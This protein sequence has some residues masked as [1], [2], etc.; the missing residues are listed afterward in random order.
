MSTSYRPGRTTDRDSHNVYDRP[1]VEPPLPSQYAMPTAA[2]LVLS[3]RV[4]A[5][6]A[7]VVRHDPG[8]SQYLTAMTP[9]GMQFFRVTVGQFPV[10]SIVPTTL[11][12]ATTGVTGERLQVSIATLGLKDLRTELAVLIDPTRVDTSNDTAPAAIE[13]CPLAESPGIPP[14]VNQHFGD[15]AASI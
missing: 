8:H 14:A 5:D 4:V 10:P 15:A 13:L 12:G 2:E 1:P 7:I 6:A 11:E 3:F 9:A